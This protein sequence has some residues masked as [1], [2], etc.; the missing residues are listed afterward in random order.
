VLRKPQRF[1]AVLSRT[2]TTGVD[3]MRFSSFRHS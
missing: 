1:N 2:L 3:F